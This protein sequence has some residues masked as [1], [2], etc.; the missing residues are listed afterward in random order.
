MFFQHKNHWRSN[1][2]FPASKAFVSC[3]TCKNNI[4]YTYVHG[5]PTKQIINRFVDCYGLKISTCDSLQSF[6]SK[7]WSVFKLRQFE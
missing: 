2:K 6:K 3:S 5:V 1:I 4:F 7:V